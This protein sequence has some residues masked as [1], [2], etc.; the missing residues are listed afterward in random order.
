MLPRRPIMCPFYQP[1]DFEQ[2]ERDHL[3][4]VGK[5]AQGASPKYIVRIIHFVPSDRSPQEDVGT[6]IDALIK[7]VQQFYAD[8]ME[9]HGLGRKTFRFETD[10]AGKAVVHHVMG[11]FDTGHYHTKHGFPDVHR[12]ITEQ[13]GRPNNIVYFIWKDYGAHP[14]ISGRSG[15]GHGDSFGGIVELSTYNIATGPIRYW[16]VVAHELGHGF[17][18]AHDFRNDRYIMSYGPEEFQNQLSQ[19]AAEWLDGPSLFQYQP[20]FLRLTSNGS[21]D[22]PFSCIST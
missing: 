20:N 3:R 5:L 21:D 17:G 7:R 15:Y 1:L 14:H 2:R 18:L 6:Q 16:K 10:A 19:C 4:P 11:K 22:A 8:E 13:L 9:R 12:E